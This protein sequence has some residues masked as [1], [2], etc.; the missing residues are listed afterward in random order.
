MQRAV[1]EPL[2]PERDGALIGA[3]G[4][5]R[6]RYALVAP[7]RR[8]AGGAGALIAMLS[9]RPPDEALA[10][11]TA[12]ACAATLALCTHRPEML[13]TLLQAS[14]FDALTGCLN[15]AG[16]PSAAV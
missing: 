2:R 9:V 16:D 14:R 15:Y 7:I 11:W 13:D 3:A 1:L 8:A 12:E 4:D 10:L 5:P 6:P